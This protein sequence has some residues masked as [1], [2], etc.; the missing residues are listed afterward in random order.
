MTDP[1]MGHDQLSLALR[2]AGGRGTT[3]KHRLM[4]R[5]ADAIGEVEQMLAAIDDV[6]E[7]GDHDAVKLRLKHIARVLGHEN[8]VTNDVYTDESR[9]NEKRNMSTNGN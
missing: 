1:R 4:L 7:H 6:M 5:A 3:D 8:T 2:H 9:H